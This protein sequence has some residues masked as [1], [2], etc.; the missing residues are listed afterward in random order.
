MKTFVWVLLLV[1]AISFI[2]GFSQTFSQPKVRSE[3]M[4]EP[5]IQQPRTYN[6]IEIQK[7]DGDIY[8]VRILALSSSFGSQGVELLHNGNKVEGCSAFHVGAG[9]AAI[10]CLVKLVEGDTISF[11][12]NMN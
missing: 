5:R 6:V 11:I 7:A 8:R 2:V 9:M 12:A 1:A 3:T 10:P 4:T